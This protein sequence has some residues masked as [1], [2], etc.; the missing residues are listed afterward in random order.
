MWGQAKA[1]AAFAL[2]LVKQEGLSAAGRVNVIGLFA[3]F[4]L[5]VAM[6]LFDL[7]EVIG[8]QF[9]LDLGSAPS[10]LTLFIVFVVSNLLCVLILALTD[11]DRQ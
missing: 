3:T 6:G 8:R 1:L 4:L 9:D 2:D 11:P 5:V 7:M 10:F